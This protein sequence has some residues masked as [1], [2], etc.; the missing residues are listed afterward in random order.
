LFK[1]GVWV[2]QCFLVAVG[3]AMHRFSFFILLFLLMQLL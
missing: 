1:A 2:S 3:E